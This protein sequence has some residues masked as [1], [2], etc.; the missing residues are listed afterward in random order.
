MFAASAVT[1]TASTLMQNRIT[2]GFATLVSITAASGAAAGAFTVRLRGT[3]DILAGGQGTVNFQFGL[4]AVGTVV[5]VIA[6]SNA[7]VWPL[8]PISAITT[9]TSIGSWA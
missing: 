8:N 2:S 9:D 5:T 3:F 1:P 4:T 6:G 7:Q